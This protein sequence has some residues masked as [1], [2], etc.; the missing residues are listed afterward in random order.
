MGDHD[1]S[2]L[3]GELKGELTA[4]KGQN[5]DIKAHLTRQ[6]ERTE[7]NKKA[8]IDARQRLET[9]VDG[10]GKTTAE[11]AEWIRLHGAPMA[12]E[13]AQSRE[14]KKL[15]AAEFRGRVK[16]WAKIGG[17]LTLLITGIGYLGK[18]AVAAVLRK[19]ANLL[20]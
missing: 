5:Q 9:K 11:H 13:W 20:G 18:D 4:I 12:R 7:V 17:G 2:L 6:D 3:V 1:L 10:I 15:A 16:T 14:R 19:V 8:A